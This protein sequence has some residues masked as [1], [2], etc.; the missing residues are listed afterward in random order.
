M[1]SKD[2]NETGV[3]GSAAYYQNLIS[4][5]ADDFDRVR[6][7]DGNEFLDEF[8]RW[9]ASFAKSIRE[10]LK[11]SGRNRLR[12]IRDDIKAFVANTSFGRASQEEIATTLS[13]YLQAYLSNDTFKRQSGHRQ[14]LNHLQ[15]IF[16]AVK[17]AP[18]AVPVFATYVLFSQSK[19]IPLDAGFKERA[20]HMLAKTETS[21]VPKSFLKCELSDID[22]VQF[23]FD[24]SRSVTWGDVILRARETLSRKPVQEIEHSFGRTN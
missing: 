2:G 14:Q 20:V 21:R 5:I 19:H 18:M 11:H 15:D 6:A 8:D 10:Y 7:L 9:S 16:R 17:Q 23:R 13:R 22:K 3:N 12:Q 1:T 4:K 24:M